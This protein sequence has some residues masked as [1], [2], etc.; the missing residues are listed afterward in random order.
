MFRAEKWITN[1][2]KALSHLEPE[3]ENNKET[4]AVYKRLQKYL[5]KTSD[6]TLTSLYIVTE[7]DK[8]LIIASMN[9]RRNKAT[10]QIKDAMT[11][12]YI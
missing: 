9:Q 5:I 11:G 3:N 6:L 2:E 4:G 8:N 10:T 1:P 12:T 7:H